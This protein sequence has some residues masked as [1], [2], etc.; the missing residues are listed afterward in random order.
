MVSCGLLKRTKINIKI[1]LIFCFEISIISG[2][3]KK[4]IKNN[5]KLLL[6]IKLEIW[7]KIPPPVN[8]CSYEKK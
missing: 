7:K 8:L 4:N 3:E 2:K 1:F 6:K 5:N